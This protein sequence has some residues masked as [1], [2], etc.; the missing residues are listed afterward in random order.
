[1]TRYFFDLI[2][3]DG[4]VADE[5]GLELASRAAITREVGRILADIARDELPEGQGAVQINVRDESGKPIL[6]GCLTF[7]TEWLSQ[8]DS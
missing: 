4:P 7:K 5:Q 3:G 8:S 6:A 1:M 2:N